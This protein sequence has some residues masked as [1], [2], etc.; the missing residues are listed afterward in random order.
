MFDLVQTLLF[1]FPWAL[2]AHC[3]CRRKQV[4]SPIMRRRPI[5]DSYYGPHNVINLGLAVVLDL[6]PSLHLFF[7]RRPPLP[8]T[9]TPQTHQRATTGGLPL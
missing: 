9:Q 4:K 6:G 7:R 8:P 3:P 1:P 2:A 5:H